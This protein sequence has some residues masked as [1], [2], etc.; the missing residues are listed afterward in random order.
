[1]QSRSPRRAFL[2]LASAALIPDLFKLSASAARQPSYRFPVEPRSRLAVTSYPFRSYINYP[3]NDQRNLKVPGMDLT[4]FPAFVAEKF[5]IFNINPLVNHMS[6][7]SPK[8]LDSFRAAIDKAHSH[9]VDLG[10]PG[11][12][13]YSAD[14][15]VRQSAVAAGCK[16]VDI[17]AYIGSPS[18]RQ[19]VNGGKGE[20][21][22]VTL[23]AESLGKLADYGAK[24]N[25]VINL[26]NDSAV[27]EDPFFLTAIIEKAANPYLRALPDF[28]NSLINHTAEF[29]QKA[30]AAML[31]NVF[32][33]CHVKDEVEN[34]NGKP[35]H[36]DLAAMFKQ[37][38]RSGYRG[39]FSMEVETRAVDPIIGTKRL[40]AQTLQ[41][42]S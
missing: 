32:N 10:L 35:S 4:E 24:R 33:M 12:R 18:V 23:A 6:S 30:V 14:A 9:I 3:G 37:A 8:Y 19:H 40:A 29:N 1:M 25:I 2:K 39:F 28:G 42:L 41:F 11:G 27:S 38:R 16:N 21:P 17:A 20:K 26:E 15:A 7:T 36:V 22:D 5:E 34:S 31:Q 13:F